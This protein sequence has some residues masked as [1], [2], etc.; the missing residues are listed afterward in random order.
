MPFKLQAG[1][2][3]TGS[4]LHRSPVLV[5][6][7]DE[8]I[9]LAWESLDASGKALGQ[10]ALYDEQL[11]LVAGPV[12]TT[13][14]RAE[15]FGTVHDAVAFANGNVLVAFNERQD[16]RVK[17]GLFNAQ[18]KAVKGLF[19]LSPTSVTH[20]ALT[21]LS[22]GNTVAVLYFDGQMRMAILNDQG[23][24]VVP[25][26]G[27]IGDVRSDRLDGFAAATLPN[28]LIFVAYVTSSIKTV[29][30]DTL[31]N[32]VRE[33]KPLRTNPLAAG[34]SVVPIDGDRTAIG[35]LNTKDLK[36]TPTLA[37]VNAQGDLVGD[38][39]VLWNQA[40]EWMRPVR[41]GNGQ[42]LVLLDPLF[43]S[44]IA[45]DR[46]LGVVKTD[47]LGNVVAG[48]NFIEE[49]YS[50]E[51]ITQTLI[52]LPGNRALA[53]LSGFNG[54]NPQKPRKTFFLTIR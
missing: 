37:I 27:V 33:P 31:G 46:G 14:P 48:P 49:G 12:A 41:L 29:L 9:L 30:L 13:N 35:Y 51:I 7:D 32:N 25:P 2:E 26:K 19:P 54:D 47:A 8:R 53:F 18:M 17:L 22:G 36:Y 1:P 43:P 4:D 20:L 45:T 39:K 15:R 11:G 21:R 5:R 24:F 23:E 50:F 6:R 42:F 28:G 3:M 44:G 38:P 52:A 10:A 40:A 16:H 34:L